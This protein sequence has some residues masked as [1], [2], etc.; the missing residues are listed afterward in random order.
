MTIDDGSVLVEKMI[1][2]ARDTFKEDYDAIVLGHCHK[3]VLRHYV[4]E[5][6]KKTFVAL[7][8]WISHYSFLYYENGKF[9]LGYY[10]P[11]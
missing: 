6:K 2:F 9:F 1:S 3:P 7:G 5:G 4:V 8:D 10:R 11:R